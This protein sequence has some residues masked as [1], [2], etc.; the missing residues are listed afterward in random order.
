MLFT[1]LPVQGH[2]SYDQAAQTVGCMCFGACDLRK[3][4]ETVA[5]CCLQGQGLVLVGKNGAIV[6][7]AS[8]TFDR[9]S[10]RADTTAVHLTFSPYRRKRVPKDVF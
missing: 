9:G 3:E 10:K 1:Y 5:V 8:W 7:E 2:K 6:C 4:D